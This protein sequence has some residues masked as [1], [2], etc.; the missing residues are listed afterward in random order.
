MKTKITL[1]T[2][3]T[4]MSATTL[5]GQDLIHYWNFNDE[6]SVSN[7]LLSNQSIG[8]AQINHLQGGISAVVVGTGGNFDVDNLNARNGDAAGTHLRFNDPIGGGLEFVLPTSGYEAVAVSFS[9]RRSGSG[10]GD[11]LWYYSING[12]QDYTLFTTVQSQDANPVL[13]TLDFSVIAAANDNADFRIKVEFAQGAGGLVGNNRFDNFA[14]D[15]YELGTSGP[16]DPAISVNPETLQNFAQT[17]GFSSSPQQLNVSGENLSSDIS[18]SVTGNYEVSLN[19]TEDFSTSV[20]IPTPQGFVVNVPVYVR[21]NADTQGA[22]N[23]VLTISASDVDAI[24][25]DLIGEANA[26]Q[27]ALLYYWH[28]NTLVTPNDVT[29]IDADFTLLAGFTGSFEYTDPVQGQ[30]DIDAYSPGTLLNVEMGETPGAAARVRNP[31]ALRSL[32]F[33]VPTTGAENIVFTYAIQRSENGSQSNTIEY[34]LDGTT[35]IS[36]GLTD[37]TQD[38]VGFEVWQNL[39]YDFSSIEGANDNENFKIR[40]S[41]NHASASNPS[42]NNRYDNI[43]V[44]GT[45]LQNDLSLFELTANQI[46][47]YP[48]PANDVVS[49]SAESE[50]QKL[51][52]FDAVG[53]LVLH[54]EQINGDELSFDVSTLEAGV[55]T[56]LV[57]TANGFKQIRF[58]K[59]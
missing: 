57:Q 45:L 46:Q 52:V 53:A 1:F 59:N 44:T 48:N 41:Y 3:W 21:L 10:A 27:T 34:S 14:V 38:V 19:D 29:V 5:F 32:V 16:N 30:R 36:A 35:F 23:G 47:V 28:F 4:L 13:V 18:I 17:L 55:Y 25:F 43:T 15:A 37:N 22:H 49:I 56:I 42:G 2:I 33:D 12:G 7:M 39:T 31:A 51:F 50:V 9:T 20:T 8:G 40:I 24:T 11:Q 6:S 58:V 54:F 26:P